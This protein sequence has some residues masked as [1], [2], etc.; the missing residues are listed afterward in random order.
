MEIKDL[1]CLEEL[2]D[3]QIELI[4]GGGWFSDAFD[5]LVNWISKDSKDGSAE[6]A[7]VSTGKA[8]IL[9]PVVGGLALMSYA[10]HKVGLG[11][12]HK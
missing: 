11:G 9:W 3:E 1:D 2:S 4:Q 10:E 12:G 5:T 8:A 7:A 6:G